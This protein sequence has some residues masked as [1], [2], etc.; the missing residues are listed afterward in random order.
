MLLPRHGQGSEDVPSQLELVAP[1]P[2]LLTPHLLLR[3][4]QEVHLE[5]SAKGQLDREGDLLLNVET[6]KAVM[7]KNRLNYTSS[8]SDI[9]VK[10]LVN[11]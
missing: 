6:D 3:R 10:I 2:S 7:L 9:I 1:S 5:V 4:D 8:S 11:Q